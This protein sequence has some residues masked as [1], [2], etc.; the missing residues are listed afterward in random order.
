MADLGFVKLPAP[1]DRDFG[2]DLAVLKRRDRGFE[3][4]PIGHAIGADRAAA[5]EIKLLA[6]VFADKATRRS[7]QYFDPVQQATR[8]DGDFLRLK[9][10][11][12]Q[13]LL[14]R[15]LERDL[16]ER[17]PERFIPRYSMVS[18]QRVSYAVA[19]H[20]GRIQRGILARLCEGISDIAQVDYALASEMIHREL[21]PL[22]A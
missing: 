9:V 7:F 5:G 8:N 16:A 6:V 2:G 22:H 12:A 21:E 15:A 10:D 14:Q 11:D 13:F 17:H 1:F 4:A 3:I 19:L 20:R 18:F